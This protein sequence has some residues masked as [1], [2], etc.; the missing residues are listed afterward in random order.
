MAATTTKPAIVE[1]GGQ[2]R[3]DW[4]AGVY[5]L[6]EALKT[7]IVAIQELPVT[8]ETLWLRILGRDET[9]K[10]AITEILSLPSD[11]P[12][13][14]RVLELLASWRITLEVGSSMGNEERELMAA[15]SQAYLEWR[16]KTRQEARQEGLQQGL[17]QGAEVEAR[18][19][20]LRLLTRRFGTVPDSA[21]SQ[22]NQ[23]PLAQLE[24]LSEAL[25]DFVSLSDLEAW[26]I[27]QEQ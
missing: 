24:S 12:R 5:F 1:F 16:E 23:L 15:L 27:E 19:L 21:R 4:L 13:C 7:A 2:V 20:I 17:Q 3:S 8:E 26:F 14:S 9:Q 10:R 18:S 11:D 6:P 22:I 25:L